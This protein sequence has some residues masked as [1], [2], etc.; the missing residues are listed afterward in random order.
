MLAGVSISLS[1]PRAVGRYSI[2]DR[3]PNTLSCRR[4]SRLGFVDPQVEEDVVA[5]AM[6]AAV[7][8]VGEVVEAWSGV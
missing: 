5:E 4:C 7:V 3:K 1:A 2:F 8:A 6:V